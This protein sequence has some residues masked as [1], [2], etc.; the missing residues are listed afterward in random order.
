MSTS[1]EDLIV[2]AVCLLSASQLKACE[3]DKLF[4]VETAFQHYFNE[5]MN[6]NLATNAAVKPE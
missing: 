2:K 4:P 6:A 3:Q 5:A 1:L